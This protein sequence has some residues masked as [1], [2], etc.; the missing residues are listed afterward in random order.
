MYFS[1][2]SSVQHMFLKVKLS[3]VHTMKNKG[4]GSDIMFHSFLTSAPDGGD[5]CPLHPSYFIP[6]TVWKLLKREKLFAPARIRAPNLPARGLL[7][8]L[9]T[10]SRLFQVRPTYNFLCERPAKSTNH[11]FPL[12]VFSP[13]TSRSLSLRS[14]YCP[15]HSR[16][17]L[18]R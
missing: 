8:T 6:K 11:D 18:F 14:I 4:R 9:T 17:T 5:W 1:L 10:L 13:P 16:F 7:T 3:P 12:Y 2:P 15:K